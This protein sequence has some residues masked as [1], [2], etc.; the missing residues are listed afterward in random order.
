MAVSEII[1]LLR[2]KPD[3]FELVRQGK[4]LYIRSKLPIAHSKVRLD[5]WGISLCMAA[6]SHVVLTPKESRL[7]NKA[8]HRWLS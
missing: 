2:T 5:P 7:L 4:S 6:D 3:C 1:E 8:V